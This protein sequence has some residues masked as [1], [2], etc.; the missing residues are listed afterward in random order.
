MDD[1]YKGW[2]PMTEEELRA[3]QEFAYG[4]R[5][6]RWNDGS[7]DVLPCIAC[8]TVCQSAGPCFNQPS[9]GTAFRTQGHYGSTFIDEMGTDF[10]IELTVCDACLLKYPERLHGYFS[11]S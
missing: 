5:L 6:W 4:G 8:G 3:Q 2:I 10:W 1:S 7:H 11:R 9:S